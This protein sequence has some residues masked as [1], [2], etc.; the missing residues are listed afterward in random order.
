MLCRSVDYTLDNL[1]E[2]SEA[3]PPP[4]LDSR[5]VPGYRPTWLE[6]FMLRGKPQDR[7]AYNRYCRGQ[8]M[9]LLVY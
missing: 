5:G 2:Y 8:G 4:P 6:A 7:E 3:A 9:V 1:S